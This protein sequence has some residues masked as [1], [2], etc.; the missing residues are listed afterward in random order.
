MSLKTID[1]RLCIIGGSSRCGKTTHTL[2]LIKPFKTVF[3]WDIEAQWCNQAGFKKITSLVELKKIVQSGK[4]GRY[5]YVSGGNIKAEFELFCKCVFHY[6][7]F[8]GECAVVAEELADVTTTAKAPE[9][10]GILCR[11]GLKRSISIFAISQRWAE[12]DKT[13][14]GNATDFYLFRMS[15]G[16][17]IKYMA[18]KTRV[19]V[20]VLESLNAFE[21]AHYS[22]IDKKT[23]LHKLNFKK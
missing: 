15:S 19:S 5:A 9:S 16:D 3:V 6:G 23:T 12:A 11:R 10:W 22:V 17:D 21:F 4:A 20:E 1:G 8:F 13:A 7:A 18:R 2:K 14:L